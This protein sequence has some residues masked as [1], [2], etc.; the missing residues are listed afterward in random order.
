MEHIESKSQYK[1]M[2]QKKYIYWDKF[3]IMVMSD[4]GFQVDFCVVLASE[5][6]LM[7]DKVAFYGNPLVVFSF[8]KLFQKLPFLAS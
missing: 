6:V 3:N 1:Y 7:S 8:Y 2:K 5:K 4:V